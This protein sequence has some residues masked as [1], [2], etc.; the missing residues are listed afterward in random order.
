MP[1]CISRWTGLQD[2]KYSDLWHVW[3][4]LVGVIALMAAA[5][6][7]FF[8]GDFWPLQV[9]VVFL[10]GYLAFMLLLLVLARLIVRH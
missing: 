9:V 8:G 4:I 1:S 6:E 5:S 3:G 10:A 2:E 7:G